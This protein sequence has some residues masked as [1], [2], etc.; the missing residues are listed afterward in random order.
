MFRVYNPDLN[1]GFWVHSFS[2]KQT[3]D[4]GTPQIFLYVKTNL[5]FFDVLCV[6]DA[7]FAE[8]ERER[9]K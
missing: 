7:K 9:E 4:K 8:E 2:Q 1:L 3:K 5:I 6:L